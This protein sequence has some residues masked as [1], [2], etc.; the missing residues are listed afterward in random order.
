MIDRRWVIPLAAALAA[1]PALAA[2]ATAPNPFAT[3]ASGRLAA[4]TP[5]WTAASDRSHHGSRRM[6]S[7]WSHSMRNA[8]CPAADA[9]S[10]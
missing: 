4:I 3:T 10:R 2:Q 6:A 9:I 1:A 7:T 8:S 5:G